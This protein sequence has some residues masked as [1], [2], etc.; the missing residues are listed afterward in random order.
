[1]PNSPRVIA[2]SA[3]RAGCVIHLVADRHAHRLLVVEAIVR[4][5]NDDAVGD[6]VVGAATARA[7]GKADP[8]HLHRRRPQ[9]EDAQAMALGVAHEI[10]ENVDAV[11]MDALGR[12]EIVEAVDLDEV[13]GG[14]LDALAPRTR[15]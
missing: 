6:D 12:G 15:S 9:R 3:R 4:R 8:G 7:A 13:M 2:R 14:A 10:D 11:G 5:R 1:M